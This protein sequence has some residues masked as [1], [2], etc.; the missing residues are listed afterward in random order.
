MKCEFIAILY[1]E[2]IYESH[3]IA[4]S[5]FQSEREVHHDKADIYRYVDVIWI[6]WD[7]AVAYRQGS[8]Q[9]AAQMWEKHQLGEID[10]VL[11]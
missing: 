10:I 4:R 7:N 3:E 5:Y 1:E 6:H 2:E 9:I 11:G 8:G